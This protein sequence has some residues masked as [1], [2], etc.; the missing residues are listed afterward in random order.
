MSWLSEVQL[1]HGD[2]SLEPLREAHAAELVDVL[3][4]GN[5]WELWFTLVPT[6]ENL[7]AYLADAFAMQEAGT[8]IPFLIRHHGKAVGSTR[9]CNIEA[10]NRRA[11]IGYTWLAKSVQRSAVNSTCKLLLLEYLFETR[12]AIAVEFRTNF[13]N[14]ASRRAIERLGAKLDGVLR[15]HRIQP[16]G[17]FRDTVVYSILDSEWPAVRLSLEHALRPRA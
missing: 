4:D 1:T 6:P 14:H 7:A 5:L 16:E 12:D 17:G 2:V 13:H 9:F 8:A 3:H 15:Q 11:E 10:S